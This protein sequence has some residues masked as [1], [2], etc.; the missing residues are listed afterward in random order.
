LWVFST[1][2]DKP[3]SNIG[4]GTPLKQSD[5]AT[6]SREITDREGRLSTVLEIQSLYGVK[7]SR[8]LE[9]DIKSLSWFYLRVEHIVLVA[10]HL[11]R[12]AHST[13]QQT[14]KSI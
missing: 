12:L 2:G 4:G 8:S 5:T 14:R 1:L 7:F 11:L 13:V 10:L 6:K 9:I 3:F